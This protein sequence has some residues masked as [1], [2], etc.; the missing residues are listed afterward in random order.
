MRLLLRGG[1]VYENGVFS[2]KDIAVHDGIIVGIERFIPDKE[3]DSF[4]DVADCHI[5]PGL[6]DVHVHLREPGFF[7]K[8]TIKSG[9]A[10]AARGGFT[11]VCAMPNLDPTPDCPESLSVETDII[12]RTASIAVYPIGCI[13]RGEKGNE[14]ADIA[15]M[16]DAIAFSDDGRGV[17]HADIMERAM[18]AV[19]KEGKLIAAHCE[20]D[21]LAAGGVI[22]EC[23]YAKEHGLKGISSKSEWAQI[24][25]DIELVRKTGCPYHVCHIST[26]ESVELIRRAKAEGLSVSCETAP[27][28]FALSDGML[29]DDGAYRMNPPIR[30]EADR[31]AIITGI[32]DG[33]IDMIAT[34]HAPHSYEEKA[35]GIAGSK[36]GIVGLE[37]AFPVAYTCL[38][39][40][41]IITLERLTELMSV[42]PRRRFGLKPGVIA[43]G[44]R[45]DLTVINLNTEYS[46]DPARFLS[47]G[48]ST[49]F[50]GRKV[51]GDILYTMFD[52]RTVW[53]GAATKS[54]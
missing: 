31:L 6:A 17:Q 20:D 45:A 27:H 51:F 36:N 18:L 48:K 9:T 50:A 15:G 2:R 39:R 14:L 41:G 12:R 8:E 11:A 29:K 5:F 7:Y 25:R 16:K 43:V 26:R 21:A 53:Q 1:L 30:R 44:E 4:L 38:V 28:Y 52:G 10:A 13:T 32:Q 23:E 22:N 37:T 35:Q 40:T 24:E 46:I 49:P 54:L 33:T 47:K 3:H 34:D 19:K 42:A